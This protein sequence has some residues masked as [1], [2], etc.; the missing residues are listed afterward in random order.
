MPD[1]NDKRSA[2]FSIYLVHSLKLAVGQPYA[3]HQL[4]KSAL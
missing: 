1:P 4:S 2:S 3:S